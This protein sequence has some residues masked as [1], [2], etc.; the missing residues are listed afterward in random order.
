MI[1]TTWDGHLR[2]DRS[3]D[4]ASV[5]L[6]L[7]TLEPTTEAQV[8]AGLVV[9]FVTGDPG[10]PPARVTVSTPQGRLPDDVAALLGD[11][12]A[13]AVA[14][15]ASTGATGD[16]LQLDLVE[17]D[18]LAAAWAPYRVRVLTAA[19]VWDATSG[20]WANGLWTALEL[21]DWREFVRGPALSPVFRGEPTSPVGGDLDPPMAEGQWLLPASIAGEAGCA[22]T[23][24]WSV[25]PGPQGTVRVEVETERVDRGRPTLLL[26]GV[27]GPDDAWEPLRADDGGRLQARLVVRG[28]GPVPLRFRTEPEGGS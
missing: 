10:G 8:R 14:A 11:R 13:V 21:P 15:L 3:P 23:V 24:F 26:V 7:L 2:V 6:T 16:W 5:T 9:G 19:R 4:G 28:D 25:R 20:A 12:V 27:D 17:V 1:V 18:D 22:R